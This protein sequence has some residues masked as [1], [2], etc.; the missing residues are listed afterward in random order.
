MLALAFRSKFDI[1]QAQGCGCTFI[2]S[3]GESVADVARLC[4]GN[5]VQ[6][7]LADGCCTNRQSVQLQLNTCQPNC[8][9]TCEPGLKYLLVLLRQYSPHVQALQLLFSM[10]HVCHNPWPWQLSLVMKVWP[11]LSLN[12]SYL[13]RW[14]QAMWL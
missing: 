5:S 7:L 2:L 13:R 11:C 1:A 3:Y 14:Q 12:H 9:S 10:V 6:Q 8:T 4:R